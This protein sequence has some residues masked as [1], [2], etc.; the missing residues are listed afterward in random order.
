MVVE[1]DN[2][3]VLVP[4]GMAIILVSWLAAVLAGNFIY[5]PALGRKY[6]SK[7]KKGYKSFN[8]SLAI[9][10]KTI[11]SILLIKSRGCSI[12]RLKFLRSQFI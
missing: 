4:T 7:S 2:G 8:W 1:E 11:S 9:N 5:R 12:I 3:K 10:G 6:L